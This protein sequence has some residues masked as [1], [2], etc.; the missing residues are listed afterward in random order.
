MGTIEIA[1]MES[2]LTLFV[3]SKSRII[4]VRITEFS[5]TEE[6]FDI[7]LNPLR[8]KLNLGFQVLNVDDLGFDHKGG[9]LYMAYQQNKEALART[10]S[11]GT[12]GNL[13]IQSIT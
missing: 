3:W 7:N 12:L 9:S 10:F 6:A 2:S 5:I 11:S 1:P 4:P 8:A 13:G